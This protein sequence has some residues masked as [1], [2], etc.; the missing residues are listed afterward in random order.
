VSS[1]VRRLLSTKYDM[2]IRA[3]EEALVLAESE[4]PKLQRVVAPR[5]R[6]AY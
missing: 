2:V 6:T 5:D 4:K 1:F 3:F